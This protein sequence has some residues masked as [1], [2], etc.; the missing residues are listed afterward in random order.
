MEV[1]EKVGVIQDR[2][3]TQSI[4][5]VAQTTLIST[6]LT[7]LVYRIYCDVLTPAADIETEL[8]PGAYGKPQLSS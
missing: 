2:L 5:P 4:S 3:Q 8:S 1:G 7:A 6:G